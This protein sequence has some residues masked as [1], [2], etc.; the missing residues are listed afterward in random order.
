MGGTVNVQSEVGQ[1]S[2]FSIIFKV[3]CKVPCFKKNSSSKVL[4]KLP[5]ITTLLQSKELGFTP[6]LL[7][8]NDEPF[9][10]QGYQSQLENWFEVK[11]AE[12]G[13]QALQIVSSQEANYFDVI[14][15]DINMPIM[16]GFEACNLIDL[17]LASVGQ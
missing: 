14:I 2:T 17:H 9:L 5:S 4:R 10:L 16:D 6:R 8:A 3:M 1:G 11:T 15:L 13:L 7:I 12:N